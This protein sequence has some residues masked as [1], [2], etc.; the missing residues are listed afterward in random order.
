MIRL[1]STLLSLPLILLL[2]GAAGFALSLEAQ[3]LVR[4]QAQLEQGDLV[5]V[6]QILGRQGPRDDRAAESRL[7]LGE[8]DLNLALR[9]LLNQYHD[10]RG[11]VTLSSGLLHGEFTW[12]L[13]NSPARPY[14]NLALNLEAKNGRTRITGLRLGRL[15]LPMA[16]DGHWLADLLGR[17]FSREELPLLHAEIRRLVITPERMTL[18]YQWDPK[19]LEQVRSLAM[20]EAERK[21]ALIHFRALALRLRNPPGDLAEL[22]RDSLRLAAER[23]RETGDEIRENRAALVALGFYALGRSADRLIDNGESLPRLPAGWVRLQAREDLSRHFLVSAAVSA[24]SDSNLSDVIGLYKEWSDSRGGSGFSFVDLAADRAGT[25]FGEIAT[26]DT[27]S[28]RRLLRIAAG[29]IEDGDLLPPVRDL[30]ENLSEDDFEK[31]F[32]GIG[33]PRYRHMLDTIERRLDAL[34]LYRR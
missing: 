21:T 16:L 30:P 19:L 14:L 8:S 23:S 4:H 1:I 6:K 32:G 29:N 22:L 26:K 33:E 11:R 5:R 18:Y 9:Y 2:V 3:P 25:R 20:D 28:A 7:E 27:A 10:G 17:L 15:D 24:S 13:S 12:R 34:P 31:A